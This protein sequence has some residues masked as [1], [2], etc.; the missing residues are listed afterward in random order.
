MTEHV[1]IMLDN[2]N[3]A[4]LMQELL[5]NQEVWEKNDFQLFACRIFNESFSRFGPLRHITIIYFSSGGKHRFFFFNN[6]I[7]TFLA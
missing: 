3:Y 7:A 6:E 5:W 2:D 4:F 1:S